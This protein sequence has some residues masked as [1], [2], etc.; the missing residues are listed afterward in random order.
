[1]PIAVAPPVLKDLFR[2]I[3][4]QHHAVFVLLEP[5][6]CLLM[7][8]GRCL[9]TPLNCHRTILLKSGRWS[10]CEVELREHE[11]RLAVALCGCLP[12]PLNRCSFILLNSFA[13]PQCFRNTELSMCQ[14][15]L[16]AR[17]KPSIC[18]MLC[19]RTLALASIAQRQLS[20]GELRLW[21]SFSRGRFEEWPRCV[22]VDLAADAKPVA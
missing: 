4:R 7:P 9:T 14:A 20:E 19:L 1:M 6:L 21:L 8:R 5:F 15:V 11:G 10:V 16:G 22:V 12:H 2:D 3:R 13:L 18:I 17:Q